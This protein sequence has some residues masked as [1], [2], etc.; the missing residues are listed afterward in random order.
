MKFK[1]LSLFFKII[2]II[3]IIILSP[4]ITLSF[5]FIFV[6]LIILVPI[7][8]IRY[9]KSNFFISQNKKYIIGI[10][11]NDYYKVINYLEKK[12]INYIFLDNEKELI[13]NNKK[14]LFPWFECISF[15]EKGNCIISEEDNYDFVPLDIDYRIKEKDIKVLIN[16]KRIDKL[17]L[18]NAKE[19]KM[20][21]VYN[22]ISDLV[23]M[24]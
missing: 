18:N 19:N 8:Y 9:K 10:T 15:D 11:F 21:L 16:K 22:S 14:Y 17:Y 5:L 12:K 6:M 23:K 4:L 2:T 1:D 13:I 24:L 20:L 3:S 7:E